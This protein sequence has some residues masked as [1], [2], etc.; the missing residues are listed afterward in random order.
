MVDEKHFEGGVLL[1]RAFLYSYVQE[2]VLCASS[3][4]VGSSSKLR[5]HDSDP[6]K[7]RDVLLED[8]ANEAERAAIL[9]LVRAGPKLE[10]AGADAARRGSGDVRDG[11]DGGPR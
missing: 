3:F 6:K 11:G 1:G 7:A 4:D 5:T 10:D 8:L 2:A 9:G